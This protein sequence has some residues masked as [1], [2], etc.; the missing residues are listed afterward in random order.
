[1]AHSPLMS[2]AA[3]RLHGVPPRLP[4]LRRLRPIARG[5]PEER[6]SSMTGGLAQ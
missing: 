5:G 6:A 4:A 1:M 3:I 2:D